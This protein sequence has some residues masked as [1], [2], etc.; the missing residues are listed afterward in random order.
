MAVPRTSST[1]H[2]ADQHLPWLRLVT[3]G[4]F[5]R[6]Q[7]REQRSWPE[8]IPAAFQAELGQLVALP[9]VPAPQYHEPI[10]TC[11]R[12]INR[13]GLWESLAPSGVVAPDRLSTAPEL[14][15]DDV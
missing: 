15:S 1:R 7:L 9:L 12:V 11:V 6:A 10:T 5:R 8:A 13:P 2:P 4:A 3:I 14:G